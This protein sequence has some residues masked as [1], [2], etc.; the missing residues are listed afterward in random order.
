MSE[1]VE[2]L[3][4]GRSG[5]D[6]VLLAPAQTTVEVIT[7]GVPQVVEVIDSPE[8]QTVIEVDAGEPSEVIEVDV[9]GQR[10]EKGDR[11][12]QGDPGPQGP[13]GISDLFEMTVGF[14]SASTVWVIQHDQ[15]T[16]ALNVETFDQNG[17]SIAGN[18]RWPTPDRVEVDWYYATAGSA[19]VFR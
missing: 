12:E 7:S 17:D 14:A 9:P 10:G 2:V 16:Y 18:V 5:V 15:N 8:A 1:V 19:R 11:G 13:P 6:V 4:P 3:T